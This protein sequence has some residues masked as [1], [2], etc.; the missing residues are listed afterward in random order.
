[1]KASQGSVLDQWQYAVWGEVVA[2][3]EPPFPYAETMHH[4]DALPQ[5]RVYLFDD[6]EGRFGHGACIEQWCQAFRVFGGFDETYSVMPFLDV[7]ERDIGCRSLL[8]K[9]LGIIV[10]GQNHHIHV[11]HGSASIEPIF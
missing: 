8:P 1:M 6:D 4:Q 11:A 10:G 9:G 3:D 7:I 5:L 2:Q